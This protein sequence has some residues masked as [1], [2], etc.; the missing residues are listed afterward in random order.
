MEAIYEQALSLL[1][2]E[3]L[4]VRGEESNRFAAITPVTRGAF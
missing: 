1:L 2:G 4:V 3:L